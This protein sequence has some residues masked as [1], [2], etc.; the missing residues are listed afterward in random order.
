MDVV[1]KKSRFKTQTTVAKDILKKIAVSSYINGTSVSSSSDEQLGLVNPATGLESIL[2]PAGTELDVIRAVASAK[3][4]YVNGL[5]TN[6]PRATRR[7]LLHNFASLIEE[8][9]LELDKLDA[10]DMGKPIGLAFGNAKG[11]AKLLRYCIDATENMTSDA[12]NS[13][14]GC[15]IAQQLVPRGV[16]AAVVPWNFPTLS[17]MTKVAPALATGNCVVLKPSEQSPQSATRL[18]ELATEVGIPP[19]VLNVVQG[20]GDIVARALALHNDV[21]M[22]AFTGSTAVGKLIL[23]YA[24][25]SNMKVA[26]VECGGKSPQIV[27]ADCHDLDMVADSIVELIL[28]NQGQLCV[29]GSRVIVEKKIELE[30]IEKIIQRFE[31]VRPGDPMDPATSY[32]PLAN[33]QQLEKVLGYISAGAK[34]ANLLHGGQ[35]LD[36][37]N[38]Y[39]VKPTLFG[40]VAVDDPLFQEEIFGPV[41]TITRFHTLDEAIEI[42][43]A[44]DYGLAAYAWTTNL[45]TAMRLSA[46][47][48]AGMVTVN[49][50]TPAG[51]GSDAVST[52]PYGLSGV[53]TEFGM[54]GLTSYTRAQVRWLNYE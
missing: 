3:A 17:A 45:N 39:F 19:G 14:R 28:L 31:N 35:R 33:R 30:L 12:Y 40:N 26:H 34:S 5:W 48:H 7:T 4:A 47:V 1:I 32:G 13:D 42:A 9:A 36:F 50:S 46:E 54:A 38:G 15:C 11:A 52:E 16:I 27:F 8:H 51:E 23:Q 41:L 2:M 24:G 43:N 53:G 25:Q 21:N 49:S 37:N 6:L 22:I 44:T 29:T 18:A 10:A 20:R